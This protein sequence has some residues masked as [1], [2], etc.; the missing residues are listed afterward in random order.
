METNPLVLE[1]VAEKKTEAAKASS[2][3]SYLGKIQTIDKILIFFKGNGEEEGEGYL[4][5]RKNQSVKMRG[6]FRDWKIKGMS[7]AEEN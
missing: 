3:L 1:I 6:N 4:K 5:Q 2:S 7:T